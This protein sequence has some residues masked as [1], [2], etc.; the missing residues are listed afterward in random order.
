[1]KVTN[2]EQVRILDGENCSLSKITTFAL[3]EGRKLSERKVTLDVYQEGIF[4]S[5][6]VSKVTLGVLRNQY[7]T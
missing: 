1:M 3:W 4:E 5:G 6:T 7:I 2:G